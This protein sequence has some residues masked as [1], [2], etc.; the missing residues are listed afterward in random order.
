MLLLRFRRYPDAGPSNW[1][2]AH[3]PRAM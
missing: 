2:L 3:Y 1:K